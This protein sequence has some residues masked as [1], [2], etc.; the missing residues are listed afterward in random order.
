M[1]PN[2]YF[3]GTYFP[4]VYFPPTGEG[5]YLPEFHSNRFFEIRKL[6]VDFSRDIVWNKFEKKG[7]NH[8]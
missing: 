7:C 4:G 5:I 6:M 3:P 8:G 2:D 1:F